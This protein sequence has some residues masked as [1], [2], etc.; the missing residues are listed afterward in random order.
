[1]KQY[2]VKTL[3]LSL[4][5]GCVISGSNIASA[6]PLTFTGQNAGI[7][8]TANPSDTAAMMN[9]VVKPNNPNIVSGTAVS[10]SQFILQSLE[11]QISNKIFTT[12][13][14]SAPGDAGTFAL[15]DG[16]S[17]AYTNVAGTITVTITNASGV[18]TTVVLP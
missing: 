13:E 16:S 10:S 18:V 15:S 12:I 2:I 7:F 4:I 17:I 3:S 14:N 8:P 5:A 6:N 9:S 1:M 11:S